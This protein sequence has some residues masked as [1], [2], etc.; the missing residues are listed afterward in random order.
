[1]AT[2]VAA[3]LALYAVDHSNS[4]QVPTSHAK[5]NYSYVENIPDLIRV[6]H[7][8]NAL[9][10]GSGRPL[11]IPTI[12]VRN[13]PQTRGDGGSPRFSG[14]FVGGADAG[15]VSHTDAHCLGD[16]W[17]RLTGTITSRPCP[18]K[19]EATCLRAPIIYDTSSN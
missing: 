7:V 15:R 16:G 8:Q 9:A 1:L 19:S 17:G 10:A 11:A 13:V 6:R 12:A 18:Q 3:S 5:L 14:S 2:G 4:E